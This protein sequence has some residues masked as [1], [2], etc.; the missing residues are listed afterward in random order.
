MMLA[1]IHE[2]P[3]TR[4]VAERLVDRLRE[5]GETLAVFSDSEEW[6]G[7]PDV[8]FRRLHVDGQMLEPEEI[9]RQS[10]EWQDANRI[11]FDVHA[12]LNPERAVRLMGLVDRA[13]YF[14]RTGAAEA[15]VRRLQALDV[16][17]RGWRDKISIAWLLEGDTL[18]APAVPGPPRPRLPRL[19]DRRGPAPGRPGAARWRTAWNGW[20]TTSAASASASPS[21]AGPLAACPTSAYSR[22][23]K[24][25]ASSWT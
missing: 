24:R 20:S 8:R 16:P 25:T 21:A 1:L 12:D 18:V 5:V 14:V 4:R 6:R 9:R 19:Q 22:P 10:A 7:L 13:V 23:S 11:I 2:S 3:D 17:A 15:A